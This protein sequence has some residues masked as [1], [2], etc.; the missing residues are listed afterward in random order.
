MAIPV[1]QQYMSAEGG[2]G[3]LANYQSTQAD[4][5]GVGET[6][7]KFGQ[8]VQVSNGAAAPLTD[9]DFFGV[10]I[11][12]NFVPEI[13]AGEKVGS[14]KKGEAAPVLRKGSIWVTADEDVT[15]GQKAAANKATGNFLP[16]TSATATK[17]EAIGT[18]QSTA[19]AGGV[20]I[21]QINLP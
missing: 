21:L 2:L 18:F 8:A 12:K 14:Y 15:E 20:A 7:V 10:V 6:A 17:T 9:G 13:T 3:K 4:S 1:G 5:K 16:S 19:L 11:A